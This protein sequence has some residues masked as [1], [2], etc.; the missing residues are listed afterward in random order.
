MAS[1]IANRLLGKK[2]L[3]EDDST[4]LTPPQMSVPAWRRHDRLLGRK[5]VKVGE[6]LIPTDADR[7][8]KSELESPD[9]GDA[10]NEPSMPELPGPDGMFPVATALIAP[11]VMPE[12]YKQVS[13]AKIPSAPAQDF[14]QIDSSGPVPSSNPPGESAMD[15][16]LA[17]DQPQT[18]APASPAVMPNVEAML[19][20]MGAPEEDFPVHVAIPQRGAPLAETLYM[21]RE[22]VMVA[23]QHNYNLRES[24]GIGQSD[25]SFAAALIPG[26]PMPAPSQA[27][28]ATT[29]HLFREFYGTDSR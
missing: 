24:A 20:R 29:T 13:P 22:P 10:A 27:N 23:P 28:P 19:R 15:T 4:Q 5:K 9:D 7:V 3:K 25:G 6:S 21:P 14:S 8:S 2:T 16:L 11:D 1:S 12:L 26:M 17:R 18:G